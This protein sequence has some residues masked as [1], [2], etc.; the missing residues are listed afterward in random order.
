MSRDVYVTVDDGAGGTEQKVCVEF[1]GNESGTIGLAREI[2]KHDGTA[3]KKIFPQAPF[4]AGITAGIGDTITIPLVGK[5]NVL[6][7]WGDG[8][9]SFHKGD[10]GDLTVPVTTIT[11]TYTV[12]PTSDLTISGEA[13]G[14]RGRNIDTYIGEIK[15]WGNCGWIFMESAF[16]ADAELTAVTATDFENVKDVRSWAGSFRQCANLTHFDTPFD[17]V[18]HPYDDMGT[19]ES[20]NMQQM[21]LGDSDLT[22]VAP[23][24][25]TGLMH[26]SFSATFSG[27]DLTSI[28][29]TGWDQLPPNCSGLFTGNSSLTAIDVTGWDTSGVSNMSSMFDGCSGLTTLDVS[30]WDVSG[31]TTMATMFRGCAGMTDFA[32][33]GWTTTI[34][35]TVTSMFQGCTGLT[36]V[37][38][39]GWNISGM[40][41]LSGLFSGCTSL[42]GSG[43]SGWDTSAITKMDNTFGQTPAYVT[44]DCSAWSIAA[45][46]DATNMLDQSGMTATLYSDLLIAWAAQGTIQT[47]V[48]F[49]AAG[50]NFEARAQ[51]A[52][53]T[54]TGASN[55][56]T[57][58]DAGVV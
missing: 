53:D 33:D 49:G 50:K 25:W 4:T 45:L 23:I 13:Q 1:Y 8:S 5:Y 57:I 58:T 43:T 12:A 24:A 31:V 37:D 51:A 32:V 20:V 29:A 44:L 26:T 7:D 15:A 35:K 54:L 40:T 16:Y 48:P 38:L 6:I 36:A 55:N 27:C 28:N 47:G 39:S 14:I 56:W 41:A 52:H 10:T 19:G 42:T 3:P 11:H 46:T 21:F 9:V 2:W 18:T 30:G 22:S 34:L 17:W